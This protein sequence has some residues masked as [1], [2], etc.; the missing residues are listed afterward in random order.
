MPP[1]AFPLE[2]QRGELDLLH[3]WLERAPPRCTCRARPAF[4][5]QLALEE[6]VANL[7][8]HALLPTDD[9]PIVVVARGD[10]DAFTLV[11]EDA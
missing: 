11:V 2:L 7:A 4:G 6:A 9:R 1:A 8:R 5:V 10:R 3:P